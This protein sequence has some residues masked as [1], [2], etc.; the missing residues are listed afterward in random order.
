MTNETHQNAFF[1]PYIPLQIGTPAELLSG[2]TLLKVATDL[3]KRLDN[4]SEITLLD[5][6]KE[7]K[8]LTKRKKYS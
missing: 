2:T 8:I 1:C 7:L 3:Q 4:C 5:N 6:E